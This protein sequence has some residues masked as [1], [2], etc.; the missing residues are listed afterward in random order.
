MLNDEHFR[1][2][3]NNL[4]DYPNSFSK[5]ELHLAFLEMTVRYLDEMVNTM[6]YEKAITE[7]MSKDEAEAM[8]ELVATSN[9]CVDD[10]DHENATAESIKEKIEN[11]LTYIDFE[12]GGFSFGSEE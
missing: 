9:P 11:L 3:L 2:T 6:N 1:E 10:L 4:I 8:I 7:G 5:E 12:L